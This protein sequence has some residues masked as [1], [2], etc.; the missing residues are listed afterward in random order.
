MESGRIPSESS[1][2]DVA[3]HENRL[4]RLARR[5]GKV[6][7]NENS[8]DAQLMKSL[9]VSTAL[10]SNDFQEV[11]ALR[12]QK[13]KDKASSALEP[14]DTAEHSQLLMC[15]SPNGNLLGSV[16]ASFDLGGQENLM[17]QGVTTI[18]AR[19]RL[20]ADGTPARLTEAMRLCVAG[21]SKQEQLCVKLSLWRAV[22]ESSVER[23]TDWILAVAR[24]PLNSDYALI[25][26]E[27][28]QPEPHWLYPPDHA[29]AHELL[30]FNMRSEMV[31]RR[32]PGHWINRI[33]LGNPLEESAR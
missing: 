25:S 31:A 13:Y 16:R 26:Y 8:F 33:I 10:T 19:W 24:P 20:R 7:T 29:V 23:D 14:A 27:R 6:L 12:R 21:R 28:H 18:P 9:V 1:Q 22:Y 3:T 30:A 11:L 2:F 32:Q 4:L 17:V 5:W 15:R